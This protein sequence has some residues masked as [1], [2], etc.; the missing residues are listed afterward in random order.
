[1]TGGSNGSLCVI[2]IKVNGKLLVDSSIPNDAG[3]TNV[4]GS[5]E[6]AEGT[7]LSADGTEVDLTGTTG[8][9]VADNNAGTTFSI[10]GPSKIDDP[11]L[12]ND[13]ELRSS[14]FSTTPGSSDTL[15]EIIWDIDGTEYSAGVTNPWSPLSNLTPNTTHTV[16]VNHKGNTLEDSS[17]SPTVS[18][19]TGATLRSIVTRIASLEANDIADDATDTTLLT[20]IAGLTSR[21]AALEADHTTLMNNNGNNSGY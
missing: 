5:T 12:T 2:G 9:W 8:R 1:M 18:F 16:K 11:L 15:K 21:I 17:W 6:T 3:E 7:F 14:N 10:A 19:T 13:V 20:L 4:T